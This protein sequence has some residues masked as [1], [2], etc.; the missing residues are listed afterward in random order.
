MITHFICKDGSEIE[1]SKCIAA[2]GCPFKNR[3]VTRPMLRLMALQRVWK[4][5]MSTTQ[6]LKGTRQAYLE[7][8]KDYAVKPDDRMFML[9]GTQVHEK[10]EE[11]GDETSLAEIDL[12]DDK[13]SIRPDLIETENGRNILI[14]YKYCGSYVISMAL[15]L[16]KEEEPMTD[17]ETGEAVVYKKDGKGGKKGDPRTHLVLKR[18]ASKID[19]KDWPLQL[20]NYRIGVEK[21]LKIKIHDLQV[22]ATVRDGGT[23]VAIGRGVMDNSYVIGV[24]KIKDDVVKKYFADKSKALLSAL[25]TKKLPPVC[26]EKERWHRSDTN[27]DTKCLRFCSV[28]K[29]CPYWKD[30][31]QKGVVV[32]EEWNG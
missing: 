14:D 1:L 28:N 18:D 23:V 17:P 19:L 31:Y 8:T 6:G 24:P 13:G 10:L 22:Q 20:N 11:H 2:G 9:A 29:F 21:Y 5:V 12:S 16:Y 32:S 25:D 7:L 26:S 15:G 27:Q 30:T 4:G 3:C